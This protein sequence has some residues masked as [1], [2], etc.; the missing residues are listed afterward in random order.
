MITLER[1][2]TELSPAS[3]NEIIAGKGKCGGGSNKNKSKKSHKSS[4]KKTKSVK[5]PK[6]PK[7]CCPS[8]HC[9]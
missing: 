9:I 6:T 5:K 1:L 8:G 4:S 7:C 3:L 2:L